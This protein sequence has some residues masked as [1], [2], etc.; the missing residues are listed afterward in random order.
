M[1]NVSYTQISQYLSCPAKEYYYLQKI[2]T[3]K[4][5]AMIYGSVFHKL[6]SQ[7]LMGEIVTAEQAF[8]DVVNSEKDW[9]GKIQ[10]GQ[11]DSQPDVML[12]WIDEAATLIMRSGIKPQA[13]ELML[14]RQFPNFT[15]VGV[16]DAFNNGTLIDFKLSGKYYK[17]DS[18]Q[19]ACYAILNGGASTFKFYVVYKEKMPRLEIQDIKET[20]NQRYLDWVLRRVIEPTAR[21]IEA[22]IFPA[23]PSYQWCD[24]KYCA[25]FA[26]CFKDFN[27]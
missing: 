14:K 8:T 20:R 15:L 21:A 3:P 17:S 5:A 26:K 19:A 22:G 2:K 1:V 4:S 24:S 25:Y 7:R 10:Y 13:T 11:N 16:I 6:L 9:D 23:S 18:V 27:G 12:P